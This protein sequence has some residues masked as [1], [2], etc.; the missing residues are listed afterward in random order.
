MNLSEMYAKKHIP[1][2]YPKSNELINSL[3]YD[4]NVSI[5]KPEKATTGSVTY[6]I[7]SG[8]VYIYNG[9]SWVQIATGENPWQ[10]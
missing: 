10:I 5:H 2:V 9:S 8:R 3:F 6:D 1:K 7:E 4:M